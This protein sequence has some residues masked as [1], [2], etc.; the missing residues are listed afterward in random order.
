M[1][2]CIHSRTRYH[3]SRLPNPTVGQDGASS[4]RRFEFA[5]RITNQPNKI[6]V[7][8]PQWALRLEQ[9][10][11]GTLRVQS[12][13]LQRRQHKRIM[14]IM[15]SGRVVLRSIGGPLPMRSILCTQ[16]KSIQ[17]L[18]VNGTLPTAL[19]S[20]Q[21]LTTPAFTSTHQRIG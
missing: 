5:P 9:I 11:S 14:G 16:N 15:R 19:S 8:G 13:H 4:P 3:R 7:R 20:P 21:S 2:R 17:N 6:S 18:R 1:E 10:S 12:S